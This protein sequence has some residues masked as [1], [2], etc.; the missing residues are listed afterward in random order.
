MIIHLID[1]GSRWSL[2]FWFK[3]AGDAPSC[4]RVDMS[5]WWRGAAEAGDAVAQFLQA[6]APAS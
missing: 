3:D 2:I 6:R 5:A 1:R 4:D